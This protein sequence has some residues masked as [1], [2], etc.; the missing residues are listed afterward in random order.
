M[1]YTLTKE[2]QTFITK[3][4][5]PFFKVPSK[6]PSI[7]V[8]PHHTSLLVKWKPLM[9]KDANGVVTQ[10]KVFY[11]VKDQPDTVKVVDNIPGSTLQHTITGECFGNVLN[12]IMLKSHLTVVA[13]IELP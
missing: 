2:L 13:Y 1:S 4:Y 3:I 10:Y 12:L 11:R 5:Y 9:K 6:A 8:E 7:S